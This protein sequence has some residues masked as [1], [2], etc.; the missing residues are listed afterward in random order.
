MNKL[1][2]SAVTL[3]PGLSDAQFQLGLLYCDEG[4]AAI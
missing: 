2:R 3:N 4:E 1:L